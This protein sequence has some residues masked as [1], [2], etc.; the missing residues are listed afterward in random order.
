MRKFVYILI[1]FVSINSLY[2][3]ITQKLVWPPPPD[4][5][6]IE[7][8]TSIRDY[9]DLGIKKGFLSKAFDF[10]FGEEDKPLSSPFGMHAAG[11]R[12]Y[13]TDIILKS[14]YV[15]DKKKNIVITIEGSKKET[16][17]YPV[18]VVTDNKGNIYVSD[19][20]RAK[21]FVF[22]ED[23]DFTHNISL[24]E[25]QRPVGLAISA[26]GQKL[27]IVD[28]LSSQIHVTTLS[29]KYL[30]SIG[31]SGNGDGEFNRPTFMDVGSDGNI[32]VSDSMNH[33]IQ[34]LDKDGKFISKFGQLGQ[35][36]GSFGS[37]RGISLDSQNNIYVSDTM[38]NNMQIFNKGG[39]LLM[40]L[41]NYGEQKGQFALP[42]DISISADNMIY[43]TDVNNKRIQ[44]FRLIETPEVRSLR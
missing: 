8:V 22:D 32:Y 13:V 19:S 1:F 39:E 26:D 15:F 35:E 5:P 43:V 4:E 17:L 34:I 30:N 12:I 33:R 21:V 27:Y 28:A 14:L 29:G 3:Q 44:A 38:F 9:K 2:A 10:L 20:V 24:K 16:F 18:D 36:I 25:L 23:G 6:R 31:K 40:L 42:E 11:D 37:P 41:G 7:Y